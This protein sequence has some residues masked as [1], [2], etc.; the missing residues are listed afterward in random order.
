MNNEH[1]WIFYGNLNAPRYRDK[2]LRPI[3]V[4]FVHRHHVMFQHGNARPHAARIC[5]HFLDAEEFPL[6]PWPAS[7]PD[8]PPIELVWDA[9]EKHVRQCLPVPAN[10]Q[11][12]RSAIE[13]EWDTIPQATINSLINS[14]WRRCVALHEANTDWFSDLFPYIIYK[15]SVTNRCI[16]VFAVMW[17]P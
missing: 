17:N 9:L 4:P 2:I 14:M 3:V 11:Q 10:I 6:V 8:M 16:S 15:I 1:S 13:E 5:T 7:F 12:L